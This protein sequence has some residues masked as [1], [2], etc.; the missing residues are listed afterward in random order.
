MGYKAEYA[1]K[2]TPLCICGCGK[3]VSKPT[4]KALPGH[5]NRTPEWRANL[6]KKLKRPEIVN[7]CQEC[8][9]AFVA[10]KYHRHVQEFC[11]RRCANLSRNP[12]VVKVCTYCG[13]EYRITEYRAANTVTK[14]CSHSCR[15]AEWAK[16]RREH[17]TK[18]SK[19]RATAYEDHGRKCTRCGYDTVPQIL[20]V[21]HID[22][23]RTNQR[24]ENLTVLCPNCHAVEHWLSG[25][26]RLGPTARTRKKKAAAK[27]RS[28][29]RAMKQMDLFGT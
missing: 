28:E 25:Q 9:A 23:D 16:Q 29:R 13:I 19:Y 14:F 21:H 18:N 11:S 24:P 17:P 12:H 7:V 6:S 10:I 27:R 2:P 3:H 4:S 22:H 5:Y 8:G 26:K 15:L 20:I 1:D